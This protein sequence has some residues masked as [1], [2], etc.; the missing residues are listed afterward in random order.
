LKA[1]DLAISGL[2]AVSSLT[3]LL[4]WNPQAPDIAARQSIDDAHL[5]DL[6]TAFVRKVG[7][8]Q[9]IRDSPADLCSLLRSMSNAT[10]TFSAEEGGVTCGGPTP[11][12]A[13][14]AKLTI[15]VGTKVV[16]IEGW[17]DAGG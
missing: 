6:I 9:L 10:V 1:I 15:E 12:G 17:Y 14:S 13:A 2:I 5:R 4:A 7:V 3:V 11:A 8:I 16:N